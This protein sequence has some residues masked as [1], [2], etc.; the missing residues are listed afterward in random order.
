MSPDAEDASPSPEPGTEQ[1][2]GTMTE[3]KVER[4]STEEKSP[5]A[6]AGNGTSQPAKSNAKDPSRPRRKKARRACFACQ[7][8]HLTCGD[9][10]P[11][12]RC[13]KRGLQDQCH[14]GVR[15]K[16]KYL[17]DAP[18]EALM[19]GYA[20]NYAMNGNQNL[21][22]VPGAASVGS[23]G[24]AVSQSNSFY[25]QTAQ[26]GFSPYSS[27]TQQGH[28]G[29]PLMDNNGMVPEYTTAQT[30][31]TPTQYQSTSSQ[32]VSPAQ[33]LTNIDQTPTIGTTGSQTF[34]TPYFDPND[35]SLFN[36]N[37]SDL[38]FGNHYGA[39]EFGMLGHISGAVNTPDIDQM[40]SMSNHGSV[41]YDG[42]GGYNAGFG[43]NHA[44]P[45]WQSV[46][47]A[48]SRQNSS[49]NLWNSQAN[50]LEAYAI[51]E[52]A[53]S[54]T[55]ASPHSQNQDYTGYQSANMSPETQFAQPEQQNQHPDL[56]RQSLSQA[57]RKQPPFPGD[58]LWNTKKGRR[59]TSEIYN[60]VQAP[61]SYTQGFHALTAFLQKRFPSKKV[62]RIAKALAD[63]RPSFISCNQHLNHDDL[64]FME[65]S[66]QRTLYEYEGL[67][68]HFGTPTIICRRTGEIAA[69]SKEFCLVTGWRRDV[70][71]GKE[72]NLNVNTG[73]NTSGTHTGTSSR[74][75]ATPRLANVEVDPARPQPVFLAEVMDEDAVVQ[76]Y[77]DFAELAFG[78]SRTSIIGAPCDLL[79]YRTKDDPGWGANERSNDDD[80]KRSKKAGEVK[81]E[82]LIQGEAGM[83]ALGERDGRVK[84]QTCWTVKRDTF[85]IPML[86]VMNCHG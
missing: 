9:E 85:D 28:M 17:H 32:Q 18:P 24:L 49:N 55:G 71:L 80:D 26:S 12:T 62:L 74:G 56:L 21:S 19:P 14:D 69:V 48:A 4:A 50:G 3:T 38:N 40:N 59:N 75:A 81:S 52:Q 42:T 64:I 22:T 77:E 66:F 11:C 86:I 60:A 73:G 39:L 68:G 10:R 25:P 63:I 33:E 61:Y 34:D 23:N 8:A 53:S 27:A 82:H 78:A 43:Y 20:Q 30:V 2:S 57:Q 7:R 47:N 51:G 58:P 1:E 31:D 72:P 76:F 15:K 5:N 37:I 13:I 70:L 67:I 46:P 29:P 35:P 54:I 36:F 6:Q 84:C 44:F 79:K 65:K 45:S 41:S 83:N 16:A